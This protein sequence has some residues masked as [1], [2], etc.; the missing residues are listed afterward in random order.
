MSAILKTKDLQVQF[1]TTQ[2]IVCALKD[3]NIQIENGKI[4]GV[5]GESGSGKSVLGNAIIGLLPKN[6]K[7]EGE[8]W[9]DGY[10]ITNL[11]DKQYEK[12][13][14]KEIAWISQNPLASLNPA[15][16]IGE[17]ISESARY[18]NL[19]KVQEKQK[20]S[21]RL[22]ESL[23]L[24]KNLRK[25]HAFELSGGMAQR[26]LIASDVG[27][28]PKLLIMDEPT[29]GLDERSVQAV[30]E[31]MFD[32]VNEGVSILLISHDLDFAARVCDQIVV[33]YESKILENTP[34]QQFFELPQT[35]YAKKLLRS[36]PKNGLQAMNH[37]E[38]EKEFNRTFLQGDEHG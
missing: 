27:L 17:L 15:W 23:H 34:A 36:T 14:G 6:A 26:V 38:L 12:I 9:Y 28:K 32:L 20:F 4:T 13:R 11:S 1:N 30:E 25:K 29:K 21:E 7:C 16:N 24:D 37:E 5:I 10:D 22:L 19:I 3:I 35:E 33:I 8:I 2:G 18:H 31:I